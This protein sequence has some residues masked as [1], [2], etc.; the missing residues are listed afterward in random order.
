MELVAKGLKLGGSLLVS[1]VL[2]SQGITSAQPTSPRSPLVNQARAAARIT[3]R[4]EQLDRIQSHNFDLNR[5]PI[6]DANETHWRRTLWATALLE[7]QADYVEQALAYLLAL[8]IQPNLTASQVRTVEMGLQIAHQLY[9]G[10]PESYAGLAAQFQ[11]ILLQSPQP[12]WVAMALTS[13]ATGSETL[14]IEQLKAQVIERFPRWQYDVALFTTLQELQQ[15]Q[16]VQQAQLADTEQLAQLP[17]LQDLLQWEV[18]PD[19]AHLYVFCQPDRSQLCHAVL[20]DQTGQFVRDPLSDSQALWSVPLSG[21]SLHNLPW[22]FRRGETPQGIF[23][24]EGVIPQPDTEYFRAFG[25]FDLVQL[26]VPFEAGV[27]SFLPGQPGTFNQ[28]VRAYQALLPPTWQTYFPMQESYWAGRLGRGLFRIHGTGEP[29]DF[30]A[31]NQ[32]D[33]AS[34]GWNPA[35]GCLVAVEQYDDLGRLQKAD[36]P[37]ILG[38]LRT[39]SNQTLNGYMILVELPTELGDPIAAITPLVENL[40]DF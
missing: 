12:R 8:A 23:R 37:K 10:Q 28:D 1:L 31:R 4:Q 34:N 7:P 24:M 22:H 35:I 18:A 6:T 25:L 3:Q 33:Q 13:L 38:Q 36:M 20:K 17:P 2:L 40:G 11:T 26:F 29:T 14:P 15:Q 30:F 32:R 27:K 21:R 9:T 19:S 39:A 5:Y 16:Q